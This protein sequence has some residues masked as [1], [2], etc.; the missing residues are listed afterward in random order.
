[1]NIIEGKI[2]KI[3]RHIAVIMSKFNREITDNLLSGA[4][5]AFTANGVSQDNIVIYLVPGAFEIPFILRKLCKDNLL[6]GF[7]GILTIGCV[8][9]GETAHFEY[10][11][12]A[13]SDN[14]N[15]ISSKY[16]IPVGFCVLT[17]YNDAQAEARSR[18]NP[19]N[20]ENN[21]GYEAAIALLEMIELNKKI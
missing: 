19:C 1:M 18:V 16:E 9:K 7:D 20:A 14:I 8:I 3:D 12:S 21:K 2:E 17:C 10:I 4:V 6:N 5:Q 15:Y 13:V 11:S